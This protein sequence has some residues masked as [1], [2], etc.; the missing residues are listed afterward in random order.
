MTSSIS[1]K[2][3]SRTSWEPTPPATDAAAAPLRRTSRNASYLGFEAEEPKLI[4][5]VFTTV[6]QT[7]YQLSQLFALALSRGFLNLGDDFAECLVPVRDL[8]QLTLQA[9]KH[10]VQRGSVLG[11]E[12]HEAEADRGGDDA[13]AHTVEGSPETHQ[14]LGRLVIEEERA[15]ANRD[16]RGQNDGP[17]VGVEI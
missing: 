3:A 9:L 5:E 7:L 8:I 13:F 15:G 2:P 4:I 1:V 14:R 12:V 17:E 16:D 11:Q 10:L 6:A